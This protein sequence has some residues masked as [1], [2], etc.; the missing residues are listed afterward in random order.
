MQEA[1]MATMVILLGLM[2]V[3]LVVQAMNQVRLMGI[4]RRV[5]TLES[6]ILAR[7]LM[8]ETQ[9]QATT[10]RQEMDLE[11]MMEG[12]PVTLE[13][14]IHLDLM[15]TMAKEAREITGM[16]MTR[17]GTIPQTLATRTTEM[18]PTPMVLTPDQ[19]VKVTETPVVKAEVTLATPPVK[20]S[21]AYPK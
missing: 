6:R 4:L 20:T 9:E 17:M 3:G 12:T 18:E 21:E 8:M 16:E 5:A 2:M 15:E 19:R 13:D 11:T 10:A 1:T 14:L 7:L